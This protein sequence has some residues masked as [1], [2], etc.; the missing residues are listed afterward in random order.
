[1]KLGNFSNYQIELDR[2]SLIKESVDSIL[3]SLTEND[4]DLLKWL[5]STV[6]IEQLNGR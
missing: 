6:T 5:E 2:E 4:T 3:D 1:V